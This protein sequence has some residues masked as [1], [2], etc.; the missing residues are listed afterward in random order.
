MDFNLQ[1]YLETMRTEQREDHALMVEK[2]D[3]IKTT[4]G[5]HHTR[6]TIVENTRKLLLTIAGA[7]AIAAVP[8]AYDIIVNHV[9]AK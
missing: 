1:Q 4:L 7:L 2:I 8:I 5:D 3:D 6:L 9:T